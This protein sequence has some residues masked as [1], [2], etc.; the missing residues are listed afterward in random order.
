MDQTQNT[1]KDLQ[2]LFAVLLC[3]RHNL[4]MLHWKVVGKQFDKIHTICDDYVSQFNTMID[5]VAEMIL[6]MGGDPLTVQESM[7]LLSEHAAN[8]P[9][10]ESH[11]NYECEDAFKAID[12]MFESLYTMYTN[13][14]NECECGD[15]VSKLDEHKYWLR[16][17]GKYKNK[18]RM[19]D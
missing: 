14:T 6:S 19:I 16:V 11:T 7:Q 12:V 17:E 2:A 5:E 10:V 15:C 1:V 4:H 8:I 9:I 13:I 3:Y 18:K